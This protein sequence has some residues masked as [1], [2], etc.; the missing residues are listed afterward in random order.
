MDSGTMSSK[1]PM[2]AQAGLPNSF[3]YT[4]RSRAIDETFRIDVALP[5]GF[6]ANQAALPVVYVLDGN[7]MFALV[8]QTVRL[9][10][11]G[12]ELPPLLMV[13]IGYA[14]DSMADV[15]T[16]RTRDLTPSFAAMPG[17]GS[18]GGG[19]AAFLTFINTELKPFITERFSV[20]EDDSTLVGDSL[21]GLFALHTLFTQP[22]SFARYVAGSPSLWWD[23]GIAFREAAECGARSANLAARLFV[24]V[25]GLEEDPNSDRLRPYAMISNLERLTGILRARAYSGLQLESVVFPAETH[26]SVIP[27]TISR[28]LR[29]VFPGDG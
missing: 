18:A 2:L 6:T 19:A 11:I 9:L 21:G 13:G 15:M 24:S 17:E 10:A 16:K 8:A 20:D 23:D 1:Q 14:T 28:G 12:N 29:S 25:G 26:L 27:A 5:L 4:L 3:S 22:E 7:A